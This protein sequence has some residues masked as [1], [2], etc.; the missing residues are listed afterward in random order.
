MARKAIAADIARQLAAHR[1]YAAALAPPPPPPPGPPIVPSA[2]PGAPLP[3]Q[4]H[5]NPPQD[6]DVGVAPVQGNA[7][8]GPPVV[9]SALPG[10]PIPES[11]LR[12]PQA[13]KNI[14]SH[15]TPGPKA[16]RL[17]RERS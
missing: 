3:T 8:P 6:R 13:L 10:A 2:L 16:P 17:G 15:N 5:A 1:A 4:G 12:V 7:P 11:A 14:A 9:P